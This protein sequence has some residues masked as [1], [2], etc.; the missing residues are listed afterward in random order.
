MPDLKI[1]GLTENTTPLTTD[2]LPMVADPAGVPLTQKLTI[3]NLHKVIMT[4]A[5]GKVIATHQGYNLN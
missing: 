1:T 2:I 5:L 4:L 3:N